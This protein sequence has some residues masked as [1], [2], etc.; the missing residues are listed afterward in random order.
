MPCALNIIRPMNRSLSLLLF[1]MFS[2]LSSWSQIDEY[3]PAIDETSLP[4]AKFGEAR[5]FTTGT[6]FGYMNGAAQLFVE[7]GCTD[8]WINEISYLKGKCKVEIFRMYSPEEAFGI[9]SVSKESC[10]STPP[11]AMYTCQTRYHL[12]ICRGRYYISIINEK[13]N[14]ADSLASIKI[15][16]AILCKISEPDADLSSYLPG[17]NQDMVKQNAVLAKGKLG[18]QNGAAGDED[19]FKDATYETVVILSLIDKSVLSVKF[20]SPEDIMKF[21]TLHNW[22]TESASNSGNLMATGENVRILTETHIL[23][24]IPR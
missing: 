17:Y 5:T 11:L 8:A 19:Y 24:E 9:F 15:G 13:G 20:S 10:L 16:E 3:F 6:L 4:D 12:Q 1:L 18:L 21:A 22:K 23:I 14:S 7:Y 2:S